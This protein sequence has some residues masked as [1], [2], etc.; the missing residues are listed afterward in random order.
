M[1]TFLVRTLPVFG[2][3]AAPVHADQ[4]DPALEEL[5]GRLAATSDREQGRRITGE[6]W[7]LWNDVEDSGAGTLLKNGVILMH[8]GHLPGAL[9][10]FDRLVDRAPE[11]AEGWN[12][13]ATVLY[14]LDRNSESMEAIRRTPEL[15][16][17]HFG[18]LSGAWPHLPRAGPIRGGPDSVREDPRDQS[19]HARRRGE[20]RTR[21]RPRSRQP[22]LK[23]DAAPPAVS[24]A[25]LAPQ[26]A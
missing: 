10:L 21:P 19:L 8:A 14:L 23:R 3:V 18:A 16:P 20:H 11:F 5:F 2:L 13:R 17:R 26:A 15:E 12:K 1:S 25:D 4:N 9:A 22:H 6:I 7:S 24:G